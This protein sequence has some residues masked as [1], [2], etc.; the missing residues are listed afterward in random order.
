MNRLILIAMLVLVMPTFLSA[1]I[2]WTERNIDSLFFQ[3]AWSVYAID[4]DR[5]NDVDVLGAGSNSI[6]WWE[7]LGGN[8]P[9]FTPH[10]IAD[11]FD[12]AQ[13]VFAID[14]D[15]DDDVDVLGAASSADNITW[16]ENLGG[17]PPNFTP[18]TIADNFDG[19][20]SVFAI[21]LDK[22][23]DVDVLGAA[24]NADE[25]TWWEN[26]G[27]NPPNF[28]PHT[29]A[30]NFDYPMFVFAID[31]DGDND[32]DVLGCAWQTDSVFWWENLGGNPPNFAPHIVDSNT[33]ASSVFVI[34]LDGDNDVDI[35]GAVQGKDRITWWENDGG[36]PPNFTPHTIADNFDGAQSV[37]AID[38]DKDDDVDIMGAAY[39]GGDITWWESDL[40]GICD[41]EEASPDAFMFRTTT[42]SRGM[43][44]IVF[45]L[46]KATKVDLLVY[47]A[48]G[49]FRT[50][51]ISNRFSAG[52]HSVSVNFNL[53]SGVYFYNLKTESG[54]NIMKKFLIIE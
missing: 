7:N 23:D 2:G 36:S 53:P 5:D 33:N 46:T 21:D 18:H 24:A 48:I 16:W 3:H 29:I 42:I 50:T 44:E 47:D 32:V 15:K 25:I 52:A 6:A 22:D 51:L 26:L 17:N 40:A 41:S 30:D 31:L 11:N 8:P 20:V 49:R 39:S 34:D 9:N 14:L 38:L 19:A 1:Q 4:L 35:L 43:T 45:T 13:S 27:G 12:G 37:F 54:R 10:T 28:T